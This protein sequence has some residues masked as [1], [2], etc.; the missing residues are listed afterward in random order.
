MTNFYYNEG[1][2]SRFQHVRYFLV[3]LS[4]N[5][6]FP[7]VNSWVN[8]SECKM[9][10]QAS[11]AGYKPEEVDITVD[12]TEQTITFE[13]KKVNE[14]PDENIKW[15]IREIKGTS[16]KRTFQVDNTVNLKKYDSNYADGIVTIIFDLKTD[17]ELG[18]TKIKIGE[19]NG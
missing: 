10:V 14:E 2:P 1:F 9:Y 19:K 11:L 18:K 12:A 5:H 6:S 8:Q 4:E 17:E 7:K 3:N 13:S 15:D 16:F